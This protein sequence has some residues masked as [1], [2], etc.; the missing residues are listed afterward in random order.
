MWVYCKKWKYTE[1][2]NIFYF[3]PSASPV[4]PE[5]LPFF[6]GR[7]VNG[8]PANPNQFPWQASVRA[9]GSLCGGSIISAGW[10][11]TAAHCTRGF[12][13]FTIGVGSNNLNGPLVQLTSTRVIEHPNYNPTNLNNDVSLIGL[14]SSLSFSASIQAVRL[15]S[16]SQAGTTFLGLQSAVSGWGRTSD[17]N[18]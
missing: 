18:Y 9:G 5:D 13:S 8:S 16:L 15:P 14:P 4:F 17:G 3:Q 10:I 2:N 6:S 7:I 11:L 1:N 12:S